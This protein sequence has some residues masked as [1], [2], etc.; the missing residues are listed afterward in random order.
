MAGHQ[1]LEQGYRLIPA[2]PERIL[3]DITTGYAMHY[4][5]NADVQPYT[6]LSVMVERYID[7]CEQPV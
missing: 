5:S 3:K 2:K 1:S 6:Q 4:T 7:D